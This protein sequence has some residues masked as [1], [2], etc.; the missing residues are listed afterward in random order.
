MT[1]WEEAKKLYQ[2]VYGPINVESVRCLF[3]AGDTLQ[4]KLEAIMNLTEPSIERSDRF[5]RVKMN[6]H[7]RHREY[8]SEIMNVLVDEQTSGGTQ[9]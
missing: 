1:E 3:R 4:E 2:K 5:W 8:I 7:P 6:L 9:T